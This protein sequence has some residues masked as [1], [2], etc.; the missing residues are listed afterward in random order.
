[1]V[2]FERRIIPTYGLDEVVL[3]TSTHK[4]LEVVINAGK[5]ENHY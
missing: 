4:Q 5:Y 2:D 3:E 1:M